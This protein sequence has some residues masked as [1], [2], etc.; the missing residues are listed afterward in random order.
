MAYVRYSSDSNDRVLRLFD[1]VNS[2][3][4]QLRDEIKELKDLKINDIF[5]SIEKNRKDIDNLFEYRKRIEEYYEKNEQI[6]LFNIFKHIEKIIPMSE[7]VSFT[8]V[9][10]KYGNYLIEAQVTYTNPDIAPDASVTLG[11]YVNDELISTTTNSWYGRN[12]LYTGSQTICVKGVLDNK[13]N[14]KKIMN[15]DENDKK[16]KDRGDIGREYT[17]SIKKIHSLHC[18]AILSNDQFPCLLTIL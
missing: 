18:G 13:K 1:Q 11:L 3:M 7:Y 12:N 4:Q 16:E 2:D 15:I 5:S 14:D 17:F 6:I 8:P 10:L 9:C